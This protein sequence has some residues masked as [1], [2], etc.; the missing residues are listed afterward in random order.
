MTLRDTLLIV[1]DMGSSRAVLRQIFSSSYNILEAEN[2]AQALFLLQQDRHCIAAVLLDIV[3]PVVDGYEVLAEMAQN[4][5]LEE[6]PVIVITASGSTQARAHAFEIGATDIITKPLDTSVIRHRVAN[7]VELYR[8]KWHLEELVREQEQTLRHS[9]EIMI[10]ALTSIIESRSAESGQHVLRIRRF[11]QLLLGE[12]SRSC[13]EYGLTLE[14]VALMASA[15]TLHDIGKISIPDSI[16]NK[17]GR[18]TKEEF[19]VMKTHATSGSEMLE[20]LSGMGNEEYLRYAYNICRHHHERWDGRGYPDG[21][22]GDEIPLCAQAAGLADCYD[23]LTTPRVYKPAFS[24][25]QAVNMI[26]N[27]ECGTFSP[28][29]LECFKRIHGEFG[30]LAA[31]YADGNLSPAERISLPLPAPQRRQGADTLHIA[32]S[33]YQT[34][35][36]YVDATVME[37]DFDSGVYHM[38]YNPNPDFDPVRLQAGFASPAEEI[39]ASGVH[40]DDVALLR[41]NHAFATDFFFQQDLR[42]HSMHC[43]VYSGQLGAYQRYEV[44]LLRVDTGED[45]SRQALQVWRPLAGE[46]MSAARR[47]ELTEESRE[48]MFALMNA[49]LRCRYDHGLTLLGGAGSLY[50]LCGFV[51]QE[52]HEQYDN[53]LLAL[54]HEDDREDVLGELR[55]QLQSGAR[56]ELEFRL[57]RK[58]GGFVWVLCRGQLLTEDAEETLLFSLMDASRSHEDREHLRHS[59]ARHEIILNQ[60]EDIIFEWDIES[61][62]ITC[63]GNWER[64]F[65]YPPLQNAP[66]KELA[67]S[68]HLHPS[69]TRALLRLCREAMATGNGACIETEV[70]VLAS[71]G[72]YRWHR[73]RVTHVFDGAGRPQRA[74]GILIDIDREKDEAARLEQRASHDDLTGLLNLATAREQISARLAEEGSRG[75]M[76]MIDLDSYRQVN[77]AHGHHVGDALLVRAAAEVRRLFRIQDIICRYGGDEF[78]VYARSFR[79]GSVAE[80]CEELRRVIRQLFDNEVPDCP[81][82]CSIGSAESLEGDS[83]ETLFRR[84][85]EAMYR[86]KQQRRMQRDSGRG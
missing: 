21:L 27:G 35:L 47:E 31:A 65:G 38:V 59:L 29:L 15:A 13:P 57:A 33:K 22:A 43:R 19:E 74:V 11:T 67:R 72:S 52:V 66:V 36:H 76:L 23:A 49:V 1:D 20:H 30:Q 6:I 85:E 79:A 46:S 32:Q 28:L 64:S 62:T 42:R 69:D 84:A 58:S 37:M 34:L 70:R 18:L 7:I 8:H 39:A 75:V 4:G 73:L 41:A 61:D 82:S 50:G 25:E 48:A 26:V 71:D 12:I 81:V 17:P 44:T 9:N 53:S 14:T 86:D 60:T 40:P 80:R 78:L 63:S 5:M 54:I 3:M 77:E 56:A 24:H 2:G 68:G 45:G 83:F 10:D 51:E 55:R 16:L